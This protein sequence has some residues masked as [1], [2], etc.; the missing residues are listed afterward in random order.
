MSRIFIDR[1]IFAWVL[2]IVVMLGGLG[3]LFSLPIEQYP[4]I[5]PTQVNIRASYP[6]ASAETI[7]NSVTQVLEQQLTGIDGLLYFSSQSSSRGQATITAIFAKGTDPDIAQVQVQNKIASA[8]SRLPQQVQSQGVRVTK[9]NSDSLLLVGVYDTTD[10]RSNQD[11]SDYLSSNVQDPL[12]R[13]EGVG[14]VNVYGSPHAMRIWL[15]PQRLAAVSLMPGDVV[16]AITA[17]NSEVAAGEVGGTPAPEGQMLNATVTAQSRLQTPEEF[18]NIVLKTLPDGSTVRIRDVARVEV[19]AENYGT[20]VRINGHPGA[21]ISISLSPG[22]DALETADRVKTRVAELA[23]DFPDGLTYAY[24]NDATAFIKLSVSEVQKSLFEAIL[25]VVLVMFVFLQSWRAVLIPAIAVP[26]VLLG[27][28][29]VFYIAGFTIN[30]LTLFGLTLAIGLLVDDAIVVVENVERLM[31]ENPGMSAR[32]AT[33]QSM[34]ELQVALI[35]I[36]MVLSA[37]FRRI[38]G[39]HLSPVLDH[40]RVGDGAVGARRADPQPGADLDPAQTAQPWRRRGSAAPFPAP[41]RRDDP[42]PRRLQHAVRPHGSRLCRQRDPCRR[43]QMAVSWHLRHHSGAAG[44]DV[45]APADRLSA[46]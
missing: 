36:A 13:V 41:T 23:Q 11:V 9:S 7:E 2:A 8:I 32:E 30:T 1:P 42:R 45:R 38:D 26:V 44:A 5:A 43:P 10:T 34:K 33:I 27:T 19:G 21:G 46:Q 3:A 18:E 14:D 6:G 22:S 12:S 28:F 17:Q 15:N 35:A 37:V 39:R 24:A 31:E 4:D 29:G 40:H 16:T 25:L 20:I